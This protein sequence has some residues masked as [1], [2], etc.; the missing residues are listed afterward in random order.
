MA[1]SPSQTL[2]S[3]PGGEAIALQSLAT[4]DLAHWKA[5]VP[6][7]HRRWADAAGFAATRGEV[8]ALPDGAGGIAAA[9]VGEGGA[10][11]AEETEPWL[12]AA[13]AER[14]PAGRYRL[15]EGLER[16]AAVQA[17]LGWALAQYRFD[18]YRSEAAPQGPKE[19]VLPDAAACAQ[20][21]ALADAVCFVRDL[22]NTPAADMGPAALAAS[23]E[24][25]AG[26]HDAACRVVTGEA[27]LEEGFPLVHAVGRAAG[28]APRLIELGWGDPGD[29]VLALVG[30]GVCFDS[31]GLD[32]KS[33]SGMR[34]MK[35]DMGGAA[36][37]LG[38]AKLIMGASLPVRL[39]VIVPAVENAVSGTAFRPG[40]ILSSR[41]GLSVEITNTDAE[42]RLILAD[43][44][45]YAVEGEP[46]LLIDFATLTGAARIALGADLPAMF[47]PDQALADALARAAG[48]AGD[49]LWRLPLYRP[50]ME[51][52]SSSVADIVNAA[53]SGFAGSVT[54]A[55]FLSRFAAGCERW[56]H[57]DVYAWNQTSRPGRPAGGEA[58]GLRGVF[59]MIA[60]RYGAG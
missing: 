50:Y 34:H 38:L 37:V 41:K 16:A 59:G 21:Q 7:A 27:L 30:K 28:E 32:L 22:V 46:D 52:M 45:A 35:K 1:T 14:L 12:W 3:D 29:P 6:E 54:A 58:T 13:A 42:G 24:D 44:L 18:R 33:A 43:A 40:D 56:A 20:A 60:E 9:L 15:P 25:L 17:G 2:L 36:H 19:L 57:L 47:T 51:D 39:R 53:D 10:S 11:E 8:L 55:L 31:G 49:P 4:E 26:A 23:A 48:Q 5:G